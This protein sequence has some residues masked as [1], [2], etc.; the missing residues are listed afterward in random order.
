MP[1]MGNTTVSLPMTVTPPISAPSYVFVETAEIQ[2]AQPTVSQT[3]PVSM[4]FSPKF[5]NPTTR[6]KPEYSDFSPYFFTAP[7]FE[8]AER[9]TK[10]GIPIV[11]SGNVTPTG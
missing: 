9:F 7:K 5:I 3:T 6:V 4:T 2:P 11:P 1:E 10:T 8:E